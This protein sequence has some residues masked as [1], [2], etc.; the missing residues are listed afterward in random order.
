MGTHESLWKRYQMLFD[1]MMDGYA[2]H[3][4][5]FDADGQ[6]PQTTGSLP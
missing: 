4:M 6:G 3:E 5:L 1:R 2:L